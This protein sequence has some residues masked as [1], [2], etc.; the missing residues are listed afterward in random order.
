MTSSS[1][2][3]REKIIP[4]GLP[5]RPDNIPE[6]SVNPSGEAHRRIRQPKP[7]TGPRVLQ[8]K[9]SQRTAGHM[10]CSSHHFLAGTGHALL[11]RLEHRHVEMNSDK[12]WR[13]PC[14][15][16]QWLP[17]LPASHCPRGPTSSKRCIN[18]FHPCIDMRVYVPTSVN[19]PVGKPKSRQGWGSRDEGWR[20]A[21]ACAV[22][23]L[24]TDYMWRNFR[25]GPASHGS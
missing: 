2:S 25:T 3:S 21:P 4:S 20:V 8:L 22:G 7:P 23:L 9:S 12:P 10:L 17:Q 1:I 15:Q 16:E 24:R 14:S 5:A 18:K 11:S 13:E 6:E 19:G